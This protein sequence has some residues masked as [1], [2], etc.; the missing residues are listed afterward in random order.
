MVSLIF[1]FDAEMGLTKTGC[2]PIPHASHQV[3]LWKGEL[4]KV[5]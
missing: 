2:T 5:R 3:W 4:K 1:V